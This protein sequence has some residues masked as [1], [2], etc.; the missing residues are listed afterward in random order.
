MAALKIVLVGYNQ[1]EEY[2]IVMSYRRL[3]G[4]S[5]FKEMWEPHQMSSF[6]CSFFEWIFVGITKGTTGIVIYLRIMGQLIQ[7]ALSIVLYKKLRGKMDEEYAFL[8]AV[9]FFNITPK[10]FASP[11]F[12]NMQFWAICISLFLGYDAIECGLE[13]RK[14]LVCIILSA[15]AFCLSVLSYP[16]MLILAIPLII[17]FIVLFNGKE[18]RIAL[19]GFFGTCA[20]L[21]FIYVAFNVINVGFDTFIYTVLKIPT[22]DLTHSLQTTTMGESKLLANIEEIALYLGLSLFVCTFAYLFAR[23]REAKVKNEMSDVISLF[24]ALLSLLI[25]L[26]EWLV[27]K[28]GYESGL[29]PILCCFIIIAINLRK[30]SSKSKKCYILAV[31]I[32]ISTIIA[33]MLMTDMTFASTLGH[34]IFIIPV[35]MIMIASVFENR[36]AVVSILLTYALFSLFAKGFMLRGGNAGN[37]IFNIENVCRSGPAKGIFTEYMRAHIM[38]VNYD[39]WNNIVEEGDSV[40]I[41][42][43]TLMSDITTAYLYKDVSISHYSVINPAAY[44]E[45][46][47]EYWERYPEKKP[48]I[49]AIDCWFSEPQI[50]SDSFIMKYIEEDYRAKEV[51]DGSYLRFY[52]NRD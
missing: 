49:I 43:N 21:G 45:R 44:D 42:T 12:S 20:V 35:M 36:K 23:I 47:L 2:Q 11:E 40:L 13:N 9:T 15:A 24:I 22:G 38:D 30:S 26:V 28:K 46:L 39:E 37:N 10:M 19:G 14:G 18:R 41:V 4:D 34:A 27:L 31:I 50:A 52:I 17:C 32:G 1:D 16:S 3:M 6:L 25:P 5:L 48:D 51:V 7:L 29:V 33:V 8:I